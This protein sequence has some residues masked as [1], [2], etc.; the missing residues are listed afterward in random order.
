MFVKICGVRTLEDALWAAEA[1]AD[2]IGFNFW[3]QSKRYLSI[4]EAGRI[5]KKVPARVTTVGVFVDAS[6]A[7]VLRAFQHGAVE[8]PILRNM[9]ARGSAPTWSWRGG[10]RRSGACCSRAGSRRTTWP[11]PSAPCALTAST[12]PAASSRRRE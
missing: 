1:G 8:T 2:A 4:E 9:A 7:E 10:R 11:R 5:A 6:E 3:P 12:W